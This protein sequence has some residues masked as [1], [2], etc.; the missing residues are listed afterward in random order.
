MCMPI[1]SGDS[2]RRLKH[3]DTARFGMGTDEAAQRDKLLPNS[4]HLSYVVGEFILFAFILQLFC[5]VTALFCSIKH[6]TQVVTKNKRAKSENT[7]SVRY[8]YTQ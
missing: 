5:D 7:Y 3:Y 6:E 8:V 4:S 1:Y 2:C